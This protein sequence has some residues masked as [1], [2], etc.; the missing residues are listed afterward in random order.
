M[1]DVM[2]DNPYYRKEDGTSKFQSA[3]FRSFHLTKQ[4]MVENVPQQDLAS[5]LVTLAELTRMYEALV[6][7]I[8]MENGPLLTALRVDY[9]KLNNGVN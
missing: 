3:G 9:Q 2:Q 7:K 4:T 8:V 6:Q 5:Y 1:M